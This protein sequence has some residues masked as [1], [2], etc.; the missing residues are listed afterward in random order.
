MTRIF[1]SC[2]SVALLL[3]A[4]SAN[5]ATIPEC[6]TPT[7][8][9]STTDLND[10]PLPI[11]ASLHQLVPNLAPAGA[12]FNGGDTLSPGQKELDRRFMRAFNKGSRWVVA[13]EAAGRAYNDPII[14]FDLANGTAIVNR[15]TVGFPTTVCAVMTRMLDVPPARTSDQSLLLNDNELMHFVMRDDWKLP[16]LE[17]CKNLTLRRTTYNGFRG[18]KINGQ[19]A[20]KDLPDG[21]SECPLYLIEADGTVESA[22]HATVRKIALRLKCF[23]Q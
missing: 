18:F 16:E 13:Y 23:G 2:L 1:Y 15:K 20:I 8:V 6:P 21:D 5:A 14:A 4:H 12:P 9:L 19:C 11:A 22:G 17:P 7:N 10:L 3:I